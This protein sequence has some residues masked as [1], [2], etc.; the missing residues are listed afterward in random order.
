M[1]QSWTGICSPTAALKPYF[2]HQSG[3]LDA[4]IY[5]PWA[6]KIRHPE[7][8][9]SPST[10]TTISLTTDNQKSAELMSAHLSELEK[11]CQQW[12]LKK[13]VT[14]IKFHAGDLEGILFVC[15]CVLNTTI[16]RQFCSWKVFVWQQKKKR[17]HK[18]ECL[19]SPWPQ[20]HKKRGKENFGTKSIQESTS[21][22]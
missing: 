20:R 4:F 12:P 17:N 18:L 11:N 10:D 16:C 14:I 5:F 7:C 19:C 15:V 8:I 13:W 9:C 1:D 21:T 2:S 6:S 22:E 3:A